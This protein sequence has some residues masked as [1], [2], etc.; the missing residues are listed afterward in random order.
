MVR[1]CKVTNARLGYVKGQPNRFVHG[2]ST[3]GQ[4]LVA[5][6]TTYRRR[7]NNGLPKA[8]HVAVVEKVMGRTMPKGSCVH[9][10]DGNILNNSH[11]N[12]VVCPS[13]AYHMLL[14][15][16]ERIR[17][18]GGNPN[19]DL[20]CGVCKIIKPREAFYRS[21]HNKSTDRQSTC[22]NCQLQYTKRRQL[23]RKD[24]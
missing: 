9:H 1:P 19:T 18:A 17:D 14:H 7:N 21:K 22:I 15:V 10:V 8:L 11:S 20:L 5:A 23:A 16:R 12:L 4:I 13:T 24:K 3:K 2:H 6:P